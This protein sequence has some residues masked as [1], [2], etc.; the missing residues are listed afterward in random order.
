MIHVVTAVNQ[1]LY[2]RQLD[3]MFRQRTDNVDPL[4]DDEAVYLM[5]FDAWGG[6]VASLRL[7]PADDPR[8]RRVSRWQAA[9][10][11]GL[12]RN[13]Q[14][15]LVAGLVEFGLAHGLAGFILPGEPALFAWLREHGWAVDADRLRID[16]D[17]LAL[18]RQL[19][20]I[21]QDQLLEI[22]PED[23]AGGPNG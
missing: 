15:E 17:L 8:W 6:L 19:T 4:D 1:H 16:A 23:P 7:N 18:T 3:H 20:G 13:P 12:A 2:A 9:A 11:A 10:G 14:H 5:R 22:D 21:G